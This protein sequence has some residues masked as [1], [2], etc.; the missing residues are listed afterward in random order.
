MRPLQLYQSSKSDRAVKI[1][2]TLSTSVLALLLLAQWL[3][4]TRLQGERFS[5]TKQVRSRGGSAP[6]TPGLAAGPC[7]TPG[8]GS[9]RRSRNGPRG[10]VRNAGPPAG[11]GTPPAAPLRPGEE[12]PGAGSR[13]ATSPS[14]PSE[15]RAAWS[16]SS[17]CCSTWR[18]SSSS[19]SC[20]CYCSACSSGSCGAGR[21]AF[22]PLRLLAAR[23]RM[24][25]AAS[26]SRGSRPPPPRR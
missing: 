3:A 12:A 26:V 21:A 5:D 24:P 13:E 7:A 4:L 23:G 14:P 6:G 25:A 19:F 22:P 20:C 9:E 10:A 1:Q 8:A 2:R 16:G 15:P 11:Y 18:S 17:I